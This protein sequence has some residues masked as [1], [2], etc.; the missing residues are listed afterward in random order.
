MATLKH[1]FFKRLPELPNFRSFGAGI[2]SPNSGT[3]F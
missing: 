1:K 3:I 2:P